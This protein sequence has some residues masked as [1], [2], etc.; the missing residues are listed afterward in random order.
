MINLTKSR[1]MKGSLRRKK[2]RSC[3]PDA[4]EQVPLHGRRSLFV[5][6]ADQVSFRDG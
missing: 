6:H 4:Q 1:H 3:V 5:D 2:S